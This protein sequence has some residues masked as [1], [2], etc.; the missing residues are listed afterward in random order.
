[1]K[2]TMLLLLA[3]VMTG[4]VL[5]AEEQ[6]GRTSLD[7]GGVDLPI[8]LYERHFDVGYPDGLSEE[9]I[10]EAAGLLKKNVP[11]AMDGVWFVVKNSEHTVSSM[12]P[13]G[14][15]PEDADAVVLLVEAVFDGL[16]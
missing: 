1:M 15:G 9:E 5:Y 14:T 12:Y 3:L 2:K 4:A 7:L 11:E 8:T 13:A 6:V 16:V 10:W